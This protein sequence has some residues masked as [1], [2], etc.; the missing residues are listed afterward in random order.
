M[1]KLYSLKEA[2][3]LLGV[4]TKAIQG[5]DREGMVI[6]YAR[7]SS[8]SQKDDLMIKDMITLIAHF[9]GKLYGMRFHKQK[10]VVKNVKNIL[11]QA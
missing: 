9:S 10:E 4:Q 5:W 2:K 3:R 8:L 11:A 6:G 7:V 1:E